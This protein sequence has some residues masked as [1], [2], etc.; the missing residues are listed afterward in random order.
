MMSINFPKE[1]TA[2]DSIKDYV[3]SLRREIHMHP[4]IGF[5]LDNTLAVIRR[6]LDGMG[7]EYT[8]KFGKS[9]IVATINPDKTDFTIGIR[10]DIDAL[11]ITEDTSLPFS[12]L[13][14]GVMH[15]CGHDAHTAIAIAATKVLAEMKD[16]IDCRVKIIF[17][18]AE[19]YPPSG[20]MLMVRDGVMDDIDEI[21][22][23]HTDNDVP[24]GKIGIMPGDMN[25]ISDGFT[26]SFHG[27]NAHAA[28][29]HRGIDAI[30]MA[31]RAYSA[32]EFMIAKEI[33]P[34]EPII[35]NAGTINGGTANNIIA[36]ECSMYC[37]LRTFENSTA[38]R[39]ISKIKAICTSIA[40]IDG[41]SFEYETKKHYPKVYNNPALTARV[42]VAAKKIVGADN[43]IGKK[44]SMGGE[45]FSYFANE[46]PGSMFRLG[47]RNEECGIIYGAHTARFDIDESALEIGV[48]V[49]VQYVL[50]NMG[51]RSEEQ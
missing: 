35:F 14:E 1:G 21:I 3:I 5:D 16:S 23:L 51:K 13:N 19:E 26:L 39:V 22:S 25:A 43:V 30:S 2:M 6:E 15:A 34:R 20:A 27:K 31:V 24:V 4:E 40:E 7:I 8:E 11:P 36:S 48:G 49:F 12:S 29:Q 47:T 45:D 38:E 28:N 33:D 50:D 44:R 17:Q 9:S 41:G 37:T 46:K 10:A 18:A 32:I 42:A